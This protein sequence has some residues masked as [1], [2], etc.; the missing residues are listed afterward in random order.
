MSKDSEIKKTRLI[1]ETI[2]IKV[3][4]L[5]LEKNCSDHYQKIV[6]EFNDNQVDYSEYRPIYELIDSFA[7]TTPHKVAIRYAG[8]SITYLDLYEQ[9]NRLAWYLRDLGVTKDVLVGV[10]LDR[11][12]TMAVS[13]LAVW[14]AG[15]AYVPIHTKY[16]KER[17]QTILRDSKPL[18]LMTKR[19]VVDSKDGQGYF[20][21]Q[22]SVRHIIFSEDKI[23]GK[24]PSKKIDY[25]NSMSD[26]C[27]V[28]YTS[29][30]EG[31]PKGAMIEHI[32]MTNHMLAM[33]SELNLDNESIIA[34]NASHC[35][36]VSV[37]QFFNALIVGG[38]TNIYS[39]G[40]ALRPKKLLRDIVSE[41][42]NILQ[43]VPS[44]LSVILDNCDVVPA[45][46]KNLKYLIVTGEKVPSQLVE[47][48]FQILPKVKVVNAYGPA[49]VSDDVTLH[50]MDKMPNGN[51]IPI[52]KPIQ[53]LNV[54]IVD[55]NM[56]LCKIGEKGEI[57]VSGIGVGRGYLNDP[58]KTKGSFTIDLFKNIKFNRM[59]KTG[60]YGYWTKDG[61]LEYSGRID[62]MFKIRG[63]RIE[64]EEIE[65]V[66]LMFEG[67]KVAAVIVKE[68]SSSETYMCAY[69][70][71]DNEIDV[72]KLRE[73]LSKKL[74]NY[75]IPRHFERRYSI[76]LNDNGK[77]FRSEL[78]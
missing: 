30:S 4:D 46:L 72:N 31:V 44:Y 15:G 3:S 24:Y 21:D 17:I 28:I 6:Y 35:F 76:P 47:K 68:E 77:I 22:P 41:G 50:I 70:T 26:L 66:M 37:W 12:I 55:K 1:K 61:I 23:S 60:D 52:G 34:Q 59:Y 63:F 2:L 43:V 16:P 54:Y 13:I 27:Y 18:V 20:L 8:E 69:F 48:W 33:A 62:N 39:D 58:V 40:T 25:I 67:I 73:F 57:C 5:L 75:M 29:G 65:S 51:Q 49:E 45:G 9:S 78:M 14:K 7:F 56:K 71:S 38:Q 11:S 53:N 32:G 10:L 19:E 36:D 42:V 74:P 64:L